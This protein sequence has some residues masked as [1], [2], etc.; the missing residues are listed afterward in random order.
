[1]LGQASA[2]TTDNIPYVFIKRFKNNTDDAYTGNNIKYWTY[3]TN[4]NDITTGK[5]ET[6]NSVSWSTS[7]LEPLRFK[8]FGADPSSG[9]YIL[10]NATSWEDDRKPLYGFKDYKLEFNTNGMAE[11]DYYQ[12]LFRLPS[13]LDATNGDKV[14][15][16]ISD[17][18]LSGVDAE[19]S[20]LI[21]PDMNGNTKLPLFSVQSLLPGNLGG[22]QSGFRKSAYYDKTK[23]TTENSISNDINMVSTDIDSTLL[24]NDSNEQNAEKAGLSPQMFIFDNYQIYPD[25]AFTKR[26]PF[27][28][29]LG[30]T[31]VDD[32]YNSV[33]D[34]KDRLF[35]F[36][37]GSNGM[38]VMGWDWRNMAI[39][40]PLGGN[41]Y[42]R[43]H[44]LYNNISGFTNDMHYDDTNGTDEDSSGTRT[45]WCNTDIRATQSN[46]IG[47]LQE[48]T[49]YFNLGVL[50]DSSPSDANNYQIPEQLKTGYG[51]QN[52]FHVLVHRNN[53]ST[54]SGDGTN[55]K[56]YIRKVIS[57][58]R[59]VISGS[60][61]KMG[62]S[63]F[64]ENNLWSDGNATTSGTAAIIPEAGQISL[65]FE[66]SA[67]TNATGTWTFN[68]GKFGYTYLYKVGNAII[69]SSIYDCTSHNTKNTNFS[70]TNEA[71]KFNIL[72]HA[73]YPKGV[74]GVRTYLGFDS[75]WWL[76]STCR[77]DKGCQP[78]DSSNWIK[79]SKLTDG[80]SND[81][82]DQDN[83]SYDYIDQR[84]LFFISEDIESLSPTI[85]YED[86]NGHSPDNEVGFNSAGTY[87]KSATIL[88]RKLYIGGYKKKNSDGVLERK[89]DGF[90]ASPAN[91]W[92]AINSDNAIEV[93]TGDGDAI[94]HMESIGDKLLQ[95]KKNKLYIINAA[96]QFEFLETDHSFMGVAS[97]GHVVSTPYGIVWMNNN[98]VY[99][100]DGKQIHDLIVEGGMN[101]LK[102]WSLATG[103]IGYEPIRKKVFIRF[104]S[105]NQSGFLY[106]FITKAWTK[107]DTYYDDN[108]KTNFFNKAD[109]A[110]TYIE[111]DTPKALKIDYSSSILSGTSIKTKEIDFGKLHD[112]KKILA[113]TI[114]YRA[115]HNSG[116]AADTKINVKLNYT[117]GDGSQGT[118]YLFLTTS[119]SKGLDS[120]NNIFKE[121]YDNTKIPAS[122]FL[123]TAQVEIGLISNGVIPAHAKDFEIDSIEFKYR[124]V[125]EQ[126]QADNPSS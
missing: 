54:K 98:S 10:H 45:F 5:W 23:R 83:A 105:N 29:L 57:S 81:K 41:A 27:D 74:I 126:T 21:M 7:L 125:G 1:M 24:V 75:K 68:Y 78:N 34:Y 40:K 115:S 35:F 13:Q 65:S 89:T 59:K 43:L 47:A 103:N 110:L 51:S 116:S 42:P 26:L 15:H 94:T 25:K 18:W 79:F 92:I 85:T 123:K 104:A 118:Q 60:P 96:R 46:G 113:T 3:N 69:E 124:I 112:K 119:D 52:F 97:K 86:L 120:T 64:M 109:G 93:A 102:D 66:P 117:T 90:I 76:T 38:T 84:A 44:F 107:L 11:N 53:G 39:D 17:I 87:F 82:I 33:V 48:M 73:P 63:F 4:N 9:A 80:A 55:Q 88:N 72:F 37:G 28:N 61:Y 8:S 71:V 50:S 6:T 106:D 2:H 30:E 16:F 99:H 19:E 56:A 70:Q 20:I 101:R 95:Y 32:S 121:A 100:F 14:K 108:Y 67:V 62:V 36:R 91:K 12:I 111:T 77:F 114:N 22:S 49:A 31:A 122:G 58:T